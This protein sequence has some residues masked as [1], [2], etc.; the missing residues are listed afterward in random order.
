V[1]TIPVGDNPTGVAVRPDGSRVYVTNN[2]SDGVSI[3]DTSTNQVVASIPPI[4]NGPWGV[5]VH[6]YGSRFYVSN[7]DP[8]ASDSS[9]VSVINAKTNQVVTVVSF[10][11]GFPTLVSLLGLAVK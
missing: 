9:S 7:R 6:P 10:G 2:Q 4:G 1:A 3:I 11:S 8:G 5:A